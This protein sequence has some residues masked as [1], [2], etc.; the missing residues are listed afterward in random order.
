LEVQEQS[1]QAVA[2]AVAQVQ[3]QAVAQ[4]AQVVRVLWL[5]DTLTI[6]LLQLQQLARQL[7]LFQVVIEFINLRVQGV[8]QSNG[9]RCKT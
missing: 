2:A 3:V 6:L 1:T 4:A 5:S 8:S 9:T 7:L